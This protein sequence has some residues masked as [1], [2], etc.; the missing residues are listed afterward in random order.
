MLSSPRALLVMSLVAAMNM[1]AATSS[2]AQCPPA[3]TGVSAATSLCSDGPR[4]DWT[5]PSGQLYFPIVFRTTTPDSFAGAVR[6]AAAPLNSTSTVDTTA[7]VNTDYWYWVQF[8]GLDSACP[9]GFITGPVFA[10]RISV[11][12]NTFQV[13]V[14]TY[15]VNC[16][17]IR[18]DW[19]RIRENTGTV[20]VRRHGPGTQQADIATLPPQSTSFLDATGQPGTSYRYMI[21]FNGTCRGT[22]A[23]PAGSPVIFPPQVS[24]PGVHNADVSVGQSA[25]LSATFPVLVPEIQNAQWF[26][27]N[28]PVSNSARISG[29]TTTSLTINSVTMADQGLYTLRLTN[30]CGPVPDISASLIARNPCPADFDGNGIKSIDDVFIFLNA[31][32]QNC[33]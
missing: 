5:I 1:C 33:P 32:F 3:P 12:S 18:V 31:W 28:L 10:R 6:V 15:T 11:G 23:T 30:A 19:L 26:R 9:F 22:E 16:S 21:F 8:Q 20:V 13:P 29:A 17:S 27:N 4:I 25:T 24:V 14:P 7:L 2:F